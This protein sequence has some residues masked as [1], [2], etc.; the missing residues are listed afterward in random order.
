MGHFI[1]ISWK[2]GRN[3]SGLSKCSAAIPKTINSNQ[4]VTTEDLQLTP[5]R[6]SQ[7]YT[8][9]KDMSLIYRELPAYSSSYEGYRRF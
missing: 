5:K 4:I 1:L 7:N 9:A 2:T 6:T 3:T 8:F